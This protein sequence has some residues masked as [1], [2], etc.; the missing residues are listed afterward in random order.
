MTLRTETMLANSHKRKSVSDHENEGQVKNNKMFKDAMEFFDLVSSVA[1]EPAAEDVLVEREVIRTKVM[2]A[3]KK[4]VED[5]VIKTEVNEKDIETDVETE[6]IMDN[7]LIDNLLLSDDEGD[8]Q[9]DDQENYQYKKFLSGLLQNK[10]KKSIDTVQS[11]IYDSLRKKNKEIESL[12]SE[13]DSLKKD[14]SS[15]IKV[16]KEILDD[17]LEKNKSEYNDKIR[18]IDEEQEYLI[19]EI[20][21]KDEELKKKGGLMKDLTDKVEKS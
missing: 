4:E 12:K 1:T 8:D 19:E 17:N 3:V 20:K 9:V 21:V 11:I 15:K 7:L 10:T 14:F 5:V 6:V 16:K 2:H 13:N 18:N